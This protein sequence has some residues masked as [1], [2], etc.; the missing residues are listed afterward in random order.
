MEREPEEKYKCGIFVREG[1]PMFTEFA[2]MQE[3]GRKERRKV[4]LA[5]E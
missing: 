4:A 2:V 5:G 3:D 1:Y